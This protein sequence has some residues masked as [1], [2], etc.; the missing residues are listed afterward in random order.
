MNFDL[1]FIG[2]VA[3]AFPRDGPVVYGVH[4]R[5]VLRCGCLK[6]YDIGTTVAEQPQIPN[7]GKFDH[8]HG[9]YS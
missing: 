3:A 9:F 5:G 6:P 1:S 8:Q 4:Y 7:S 2:T